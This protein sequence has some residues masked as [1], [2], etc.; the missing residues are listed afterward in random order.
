MAGDGLDI[1]L[2]GSMVCR[3][4]VGGGLGVGLVGWMAGLGLGNG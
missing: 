1:D 2:V 3:K 4:V